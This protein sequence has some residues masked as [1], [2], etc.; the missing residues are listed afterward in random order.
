MKSIVTTLI[1]SLLLCIA[2]LS[3]AASAHVLIQDTSKR[4][5]AIL[6]ITPDDDPIAGKSATLFLDIQD[7]SEKIEEVV[8]RIGKAETEENT[9]VETLLDD[10]LVSASYVFPSQGVYNLTYTITSSKTT[11]TFEHVTRIS[12]GVDGS[13]QASRYMW[14]EAVLLASLIAAVT[15]AIIAFNNRRKISR[16]SSF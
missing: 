5:G 3:Q 11:Y 15:M 2:P 7:T 14:A 10:S 13:A 12:R 1:C 9:V 8:L 16:H 6:H 4:H